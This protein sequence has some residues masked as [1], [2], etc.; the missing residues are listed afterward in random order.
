MARAVAREAL[1]AGHARE[2]D[3]AGLGMQHTMEQMPIDVHTRADAGAHRD[4]DHVVEPLA[5]AVDDLTQTG[6]IHVGI[7]TTGHVEPT[8]YLAK[9]VI[10]SPG[11]LGRLQDVSVVGRLGVD[12]RGAERRDAQGRDALIGEPLDHSGNRLLRIL[13][14]NARALHDGAVGISGRQHHLG[15]ARFDRSDQLLIHG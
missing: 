4:V 9:E 12:R 14:R 3:V 6:A 10:A 11:D 2:R 7:V 8:G 13:R 1:I 5:G 15:A